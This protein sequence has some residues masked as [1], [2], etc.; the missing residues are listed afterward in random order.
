MFKV[1]VSLVRAGMVVVDR[2]MDGKQLT[3]LLRSYR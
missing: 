2:T 3:M 1:F